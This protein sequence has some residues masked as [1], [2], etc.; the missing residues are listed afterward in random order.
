MFLLATSAGGSAGLQFAIRYPERI[1]G[2]ILLS[3]GAPDR[4]RTIDEV[5]KMGMTGPPSIAVHN[6]TMWLGLTFFGR[7]FGSMFGGNKNANEE[8]LNSMFPVKERRNGVIAD[9]KFTNTDMTLHYENY[10]LEKINCPILVIHAKDDP[11][12]SYENIEKL[13]RRV[14]AESVI[15]DTGGHLLEGFDCSEQITHFIDKNK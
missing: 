4:A 5:K 8:L 13:L 10:P 11:M 2:L 3:S 7:F 12:A 9:T 14:P 1:K 6:F 15:A